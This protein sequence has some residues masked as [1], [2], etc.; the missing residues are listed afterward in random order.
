MQRGI[1]WRLGS[2]RWRGL[3]LLALLFFLSCCSKA[4]AASLQGDA[5]AA[6]QATPSTAFAVDEGPRKVA[7]FLVNF[8]DMTTQPWP[9]SSV[10]EAVFTGLKSV[11]SYMQEVS[12]GR[13]SLTGNLRPDG[14]IFGWYTLD[15]AS[16]TWH[17][18][19]Q[20]LTTCDVKGFAMMANEAAVKE[21]ILL[22]P[23]D[24]L[25][26]MF[27]WPVAC[28][29]FGLA[30][31]GGRG[32]FIARAGPTNVGMLIHEF[33]HT[34]GL[35]HAQSLACV[36]NG[37]P[38]ALSEQCTATMYG[39]KFD[40][41]GW[42]NTHHFSNWNR[43][44]L[45]ILSQANVKTVTS[46]GV[47]S[48]R[49]ASNPTTEITSLRIPRA[50]N[51]AGEVLDAYDLEIREHVG[52]FE[53]RDDAAHAGVS[54]R[55]VSGYGPDLKSGTPLSQ[56][57]D[58]NPGTA[59]VV[60]APLPVGGVFRDGDLRI[61]V[62]AADSGRASVGI[63]LAPDN[64][65]P[66]APTGLSA[67]QPTL[68][69]ASLSWSASSDD[70]GVARYAVFRDGMEIG[71]TLTTNYLDW[72]S[73]AGPHAYTVQAKDIAGNRSASS[74]SKILTIA[75]IKKPT[76]PTGIKWQSKPAGI[77]L[78]WVPSS[79]D[80]GVARYIVLRDGSEVG[81]SA[82]TTFLDAAPLTAG[83]HTYV[84]HAED[85]AGNK[86]ASWLAQVVI[87]AD[88]TSPGAPTGLVAGQTPTGAVALKWA[89][90]F[91]DVGVARYVIHRDGAKLGDTPGT[92]FGD[93]PEAGQH[94]YVVYA[95]DA[96]GNKSGPS[97]QVTIA[98]A[99]TRA[100]SAPSGSGSARPASGGASPT[101][102]RH[103]APRLSWHLRRDG[104]VRIEVD[105]SRDVDVT[106]VRLW[107][108]GRKLAARRGS[109]LEVTWSP[110]TAG[111]DS[112]LRLL[113]RAYHSSG[114]TTLATAR[115][116][117]GPAAPSARGCRH[118]RLLLGLGLPWG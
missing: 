78:S 11:N 71:T 69:S 29:A 21:G 66:S 41:M 100:P 38:A 117:L 61:S 27:N 32:I 84:V 81:T 64:V 65:P 107:L 103:R 51:A 34:L 115:L 114:D 56:L 99:D 60:D 14:D 76:P 12:Y 17:A 73:S 87:I 80:V 113:A 102:P 16:T 89:P 116:R 98:V 2:L 15:T 70:A 96:A 45:G 10:R 18:P 19:G 88:T 97:A 118:E 46:S 44:Q 54:M 30:E 112:P 20:H 104:T 50:K 8:K 53:G 33:G 63:L 94:T 74:G 13:I 92:S 22:E 75:D 86:S 57:L 49:A 85:A 110:A 43:L 72:Q 39:D 52:Q 5:L 55:L 9:E 42:A 37:V 1:Y 79:D 111:C 68:G 24:E 47:Y 48:L 77:E 28:G 40:V 35:R 58:A 101:P 67:T 109:T 90:G 62:L 59:S 4:P 82:G 83:Q 105:A 93:A 3:S 95:E 6:V 91:D 25:I 108:D 7:V 23:Y 31:M 106:R 26:Y 36:G